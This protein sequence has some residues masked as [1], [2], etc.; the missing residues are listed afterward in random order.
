MPLSHEQVER[1]A[2]L[3]R[4]GLHGDAIDTLRT[5]LDSIFA[6]ITQMQAVDTT[7]VAPMS[8]PQELSARLREDVG[9]ETDRRA[10]FQA[11]APQ[12]EA[13]LYLVPRV[14]E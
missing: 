9:S 13:G 6:L 4:L 8:H 7:G 10:A 12:S 3:A 1:L 14:I 5:Q 2:N 11:I